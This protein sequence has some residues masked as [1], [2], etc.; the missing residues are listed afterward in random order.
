MFQEI[1]RFILEVEIYPSA[2]L[3]HNPRGHVIMLSGAD[4]ID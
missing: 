2:F 4:V 1:N 3:P